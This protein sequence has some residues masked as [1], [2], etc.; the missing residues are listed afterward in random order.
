M[1]NLYIAFC[2]LTIS[3]SINAQNKETQ[4]ADK[5]FN[6]FEYIA[7]TNAY[8]KLVNTNNA[9]AYVYKQLADCYFF[10]GNNI[11]AEKFYALATET[12]QNSETYFRFAQTLKSNKK[13]DQANKQMRQFAS[14][15]PNDSRAKAFNANPEYIQKLLALGK[16]YDIKPL[17]GN[18]EKSD[19]GGLINNDSFYFVSAR[20]TANKMYGR[21]NEPFLDIYK[22]SYNADGSIA[23]ATLVS[24]LNSKFH[25]GPVTL[26]KDGKTI[27]FA[28][29]SFRVNNFQKDPLSKNKMGQI[30]LFKA[31]KNGDKWE[32]ISSLSINNQAYSNSSASLSQDGKT[33]YFSSNRPGSIGGFDI[34]KAA[35]NQDETLGNPENLG[36]KINTEGDETFPFIS[37]DNKTLFFA[38]N[39]HQGLG[40]FDVF[41]L[42]LTKSN[43][44]VLNLAKPVNSEKDDFSFSFN[45]Q[46]NMGFFSSNRLGQDDIYQ[47]NPICKL[48]LETIVS[49]VKTGAII[50]DAKISIIDENKTIVATG[51]SDANGTFLSK[52]ECEKAYTIQASK[53]GFENNTFVVSKTSKATQTKANIALQ[54]IDVVVTETEIILKPIYF[55]LNKS[56]ITSQ[57]ATELDKL[58]QVMKNNIALI[59]MA[60][61]HTDNRGD[62]NY[63]LDLSEK[64]AQSTVEYIISKGIEAAR[65]SGKGFGETQPKV[66]CQGKCSD[67]EHALN[68]R[69]EF[70]IVK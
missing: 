30:Y 53:D 43:S 46:K 23:K 9:D 40:G 14:K 13:Y 2:F 22:E 16:G 59:I 55:E 35:I 32:N 47:A 70:L 58:V 20:N 50:T 51:I 54:P 8:L 34:W 66:D 60:N 49:N 45:D 17:D 56:N 52:L 38:S 10:S 15:A 25:D 5:L 21:N 19:F 63:N 27:Y 64:R 29:E 3:L 57:G 36:A 62:D 61:S 68:R 42:D 7:A 26:S 67:A 28:S 1:K 69:S 31:T 24:E 12:T 11:E 18:S 48:D 39:G 44:E 33:L 41:Q 65:I 4:N 37:D 6:Q